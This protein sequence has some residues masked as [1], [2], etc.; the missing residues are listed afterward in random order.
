MHD[1]ALCEAS[2][3]QDSSNASPMD[4]EPTPAPAPEA[5]SA[6]GKKQKSHWSGVDKG[7][8]FWL[9]LTDMPGQKAKIC[10]Y[11]PQ[12]FS[13]PEGLRGVAGWMI[14]VLTYHPGHRLLKPETRNPTWCG[15]RTLGQGAARHGADLVP[16]VPH[17]G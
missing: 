7:Q 15:S 6:G 12:K 13:P 5:A 14:G 4:A 16:V 1:V 10:F 9:T 2:L 11:H 17:E 8:T 3:P